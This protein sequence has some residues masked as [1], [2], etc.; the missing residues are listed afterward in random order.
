MRHGQVTALVALAAIPLTAVVLAA[1]LI[2]GAPVA[3]VSLERRAQAIALVGAHALAEGAAPAEVRRR[4][5]DHARALGVASAHRTIVVE[6]RRIVVTVAI[7]RSAWRVPGAGRPLDLALTARAAAQ[8]SI[9]QDGD[10]GAVL[11]T[12]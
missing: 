10:P 11:G 7:P 1:T 12:P 2:L 3:R 6:G 8:P 5:E 4:A 9:T